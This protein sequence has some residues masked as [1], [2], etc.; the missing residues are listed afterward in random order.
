MRTTTFIATAFLATFCGAQIRTSAPIHL[1]GTA[2]QRAIL[3][4]AHP[5][6][7]SALVTVQVVASGSINWAEAIMDADTIVLNTTPMISALRDGL[8]LRFRSPVSPATALWIRV[9]DLLPHPFQRP[10]GMPVNHA[11]LKAGVVAEVVFNDGRW[12]YLNPSSRSC[13]TGSL[14]VNSTFC[15]DAEQTAGLEFYEAI[16]H[17][18]ERGGKLCSWGEYVAAC[19]LVGTSL[20]VLFDEWEWLDDTANHTHTALQA[21]RTSCQSQRSTNVWVTGD[22]RC[23]YQLR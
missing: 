12:T 4:L 3:G 17:C 1:N 10:D 19:S 13:P 14:A 15:I 11:D 7:D 21:G 20:A 18:G 5:A 16:R 8:L 6:S 2:D 9:S 22:T 23:C